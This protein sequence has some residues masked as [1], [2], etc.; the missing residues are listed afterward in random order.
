MIRQGIVRKLLDDSR[1]CVMVM[2]D[3]VRDEHCHE[4]G[5]CDKGSTAD[6]SLDLV[7][8]SVP[9]IKPGCRVELE[10]AAPRQS[11]IALLIYF[12]PL[13]LLFAGGA[14]GNALAGNIGMIAGGAIG[15]AL[16][17]LVV[18]YAGRK[19]FSLAGKII[20]IVK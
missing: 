17:F 20:S 15:F 11:H 7:V 1:V 9:D 8:D 5:M 3:C 10:V 16:A 19:K 4:C 6:S 18:Y 2:P 14:A 13:L 12:L